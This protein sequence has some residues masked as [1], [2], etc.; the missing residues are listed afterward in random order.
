M[1]EARLW[2]LLQL[3]EDFPRIHLRDERV[4]AVIDADIHVVIRFH[5]HCEALSPL[6]DS[7]S[8]AHST[9]R[10]N[11]WIPVMPHAC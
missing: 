10:D 6:L 3:G 11:Q 4:D 8:W 2:N 5:C 7:G 1:A 9:V